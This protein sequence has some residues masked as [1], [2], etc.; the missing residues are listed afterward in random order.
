MAFAFHIRAD[1]RMEVTGTPAQGST[2]ETFRRGGPYHL[3]GRRLISPA[4]NE[5]QPVQV[6]L[7][8]GTLVLRIDGSLAFRL[9]RS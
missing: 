7:E 6:W 3:E 4:L 9:Q 5:G 8:D 2:G 1:G